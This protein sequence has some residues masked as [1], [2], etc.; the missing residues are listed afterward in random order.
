MKIDELELSYVTNHKNSK[1]NLEYFF[2]HPSITGEN[3]LLL[4]RFLKHPG[5]QETIKFGY[6]IEKLMHNSLNEGNFIRDLIEA[7]KSKGQSLMDNKELTR[8]IQ[9]NNEEVKKWEEDVM[10]LRGKGKEPKEKKKLRKKKILTFSGEIDLSRV[11]RQYPVFIVNRELHNICNTSVGVRDPGQIKRLYYV[12]DLYFSDLGIAVE[13]DSPYHTTNDTALNDKARDAYL[14]KINNAGIRTLRCDY[15]KDTGILGLLDIYNSIVLAH[16]SMIPRQH[17]EYKI[18]PSF[19]DLGREYMVE[20]RW[21]IEFAV[22][23]SLLNKGT[24]K[25]TVRNL[26]EEYGRLRGNIPEITIED[27]RRL[28]QIA[29]DNIVRLA[30]DVYGIQIASKPN[31]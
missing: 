17:Q 5:T 1:G 2:E 22:L 9:E 10:I 26:I 29:I 7:I 19:I 23:R 21:R 27:P 31:I 12:L 24:E 28:T 18:N 25:I 11:Y 30:R 3:P 8:L 20:L 16:L 13:V 4:P 14:R 6:H 15:T